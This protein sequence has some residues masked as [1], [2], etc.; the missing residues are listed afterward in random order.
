MVA[1]WVEAETKRTLG[2]LSALFLAN[3]PNL[4]IMIVVVRRGNIFY[5]A[6]INA[7]LR[8]SVSHS[9]AKWEGQPFSEQPSFLELK[10]L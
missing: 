4:I 8:R 3:V 9:E 1:N 5:V 7:I 10:N 2:Q 6:E